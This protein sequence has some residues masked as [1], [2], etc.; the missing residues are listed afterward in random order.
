MCVLPRDV[1]SN[2]KKEAKRIR[3]LTSDTEE[4]SFLLKLEALKTKSLNYTH[5]A[6]NQIFKFN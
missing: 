2:V 3:K 4:E 1:L 5:V 6:A